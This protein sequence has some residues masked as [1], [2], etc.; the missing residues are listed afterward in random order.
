VSFGSLL[1]S[2]RGCKALAH[3][4]GGPDPGPLIMLFSKSI[5]SATGAEVSG[6]QR[7]EDIPYRFVTVANLIDPTSK[8][9]VSSRFKELP[10][11]CPQR[12]VVLPGWLKG[13]LHRRQAARCGAWLGP[14]AKKVR[15]NASRSWMARGV[16]FSG[17]PVFD[18]AT[19]HPRTSNHGRPPAL[20]SELC[21]EHTPCDLHLVRTPFAA[22]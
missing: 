4:T 19:G 6:R 14:D 20:P 22:K 16:V 2:W 8:Q 3:R 1:R 7:S 15:Q 13:R 11:S 10:S 21:S 12:N 9:S 17:Q 5:T 18:G